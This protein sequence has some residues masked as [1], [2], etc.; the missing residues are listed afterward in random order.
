MLLPDELGKILWTI[1]SG[2]DLVHERDRVRT[3]AGTCRLLS[4]GRTHFGGIARPR[5]IRGTQAKPLPLLPSEPG[6]VCSRP[7]HEAR[8]LATHY[9]TTGELLARSKD[10]LEFFTEQSRRGRPAIGFVPG[11]W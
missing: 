2:D 9:R 5:V 10:G 6:G 7:L 11:Q 4:L 8:S 3:E 1:L